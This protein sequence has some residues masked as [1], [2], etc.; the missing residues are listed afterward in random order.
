MVRIR[1]ELMQYTNILATKMI[2][3]RTETGIGFAAVL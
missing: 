3:T 1:M 2:D